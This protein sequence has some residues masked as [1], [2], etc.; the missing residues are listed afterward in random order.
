M[1][2]EQGIEPDGDSGDWCGDVLAFAE[3]SVEQPAHEC[4]SKVHSIGSRVDMRQHSN[5]YDGKRDDDVFDLDRTDERD[6]F[7]DIGNTESQCGAE[8]Q[9]TGRAKRDA[10]CPILELQ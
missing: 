9:N 10:A 1:L 2:M 8:S 5:V 3:K 6:R 7:C 4:G